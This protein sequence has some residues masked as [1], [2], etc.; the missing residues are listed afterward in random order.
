MEALV[1]YFKAQSPYPPDTETNTSV[2]R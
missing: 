1:A 2:L